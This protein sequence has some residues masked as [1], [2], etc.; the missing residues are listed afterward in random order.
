MYVLRK[1]RIKVDLLVMGIEKP[2]PLL[3]IIINYVCMYFNFS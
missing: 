2:G 3:Y 1:Y